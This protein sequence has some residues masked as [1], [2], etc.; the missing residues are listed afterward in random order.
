M[1]LLPGQ[2]RDQIR[3]TL[4]T[5][6]LTKTQIPRYEALSYVWG[7]KE[8]PV[9]VSVKTDM[10]EPQPSLKTRMWAKIHHLEYSTL[11][12]TRNLDIALRHLRRKY[13]PR[14]LWI[15]AICVDQRNTKERGHQVARMA[16]VYSLASRVVVWLGPETRDSALAIGT[17]DE[18]GSQSEVDWKSGGIISD[19]NGESDWAD[20]VWNATTNLLNRSWFERLWVFQEVRLANT[21][22]V[23]CGEQLVS[24]GTF[25]RAIRLIPSMTQSLVSVEIIHRAYSLCNYVE[26]SRLSLANALHATRY[27]VCSDQRDKIYAILSLIWENEKRGLVP[28]YSKTTEELFQ[29]VFL[30]H[31]ENTKSLSLLS[32]CEIRKGST[33][34]PSWVPDWAVM[35]TCAQILSAAASR[36]SKA[37]ARYIR[38]GVLAA[39]GVRVTTLK[40]IVDLP[41]DPKSM[42]DTELEDM[43]R[44]LIMTTFGSECPDCSDN[45][46][47]LCRTVCCN[48]FA[49]RYTLPRSYQPKF[50]Q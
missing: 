40:S 7:S 5:A 24:W 49:A 39:K 45:V 48:V 21:V 34:K 4:E 10:I 19:L 15:D 30:H 18:V 47:A 38:P 17:I 20:S 50:D 32:H 35:R 6:T 11:S 12:V 46:D 14:S 3:I 33:S 36:A 37:Q 42:A 13:E 8:N 16:D 23:L 28:D 26:K 22:D 2:F 9:Q 29:D 1:K 27:C 25:R 43:V 41:P 31:L 44:G